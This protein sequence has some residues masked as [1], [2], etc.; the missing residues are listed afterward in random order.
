MGVYGGVDSEGVWEG[1]SYDPKRFFP[2]L[3]MKTFKRRCL[4]FFTL[5]GSM[6][7]PLM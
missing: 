2:S 5:K 6:W 4:L 1:D 7:F 3:R